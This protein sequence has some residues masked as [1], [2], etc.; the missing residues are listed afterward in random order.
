MDYRDQDLSDAEFKRRNGFSRNDI[1]KVEQTELDDQNRMEYGASR[2]GGFTTVG[3]E[4]AA[5]FLKE[6][7]VRQS[8]DGKT[9]I[10]VERN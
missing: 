9:M 1:E 10:S 4:K 2:R 7:K 8:Y 5:K 3:L 6:K